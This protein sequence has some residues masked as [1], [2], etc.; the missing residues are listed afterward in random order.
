MN[1]LVNSSQHYQLKQTS[2]EAGVSAT[3]ATKGFITMCV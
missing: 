1:E 2:F 3:L